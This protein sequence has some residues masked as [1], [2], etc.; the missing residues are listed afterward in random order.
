MHVIY[1]I[2][3]TVSGYITSIQASNLTKGRIAVP[4]TCDRSGSM[5][6]TSTTV[7]VRCFSHLSIY[8]LQWAGTFHP[9]KIAP[10]CCIW[11]PIKYLVS[12]AYMCPQTFESFDSAVLHISQLF[13]T[14]RHTDHATC[15][16]CSNRPHLSTA[17]R[18]CSLVIILMVFGWIGLSWVGSDRIRLGWVLRLLGWIGWATSNSKRASTA[19]LPYP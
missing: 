8:T 3:T 7:Q 10:S 2:C 14:H 16:V 4:G 19:N 15:D 5:H 6:A 18:R 1:F 17:R 11:V 12:W 9:L 13:S